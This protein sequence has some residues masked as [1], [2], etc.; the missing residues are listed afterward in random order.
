MAELE[1]NKNRI[2]Y[3]DILRVIAC[4]SVIIIHSSA[5]Y[6]T[7]NWGS[8]NFWIGNILDSLSRIGVPLFI[9]ISGAL[10][11]DEKYICTKKKIIKHIKKM[12]LFFIFW[13]LV[14][15]VLFKVIWPIFEGGVR[16]PG[17]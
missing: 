14:Y 6:V 17:F 16:L 15:T 8:F 10:L 13:S 9:M 4:L 5:T 7:K 1:K 3:I 12:I 2:Y 11:L